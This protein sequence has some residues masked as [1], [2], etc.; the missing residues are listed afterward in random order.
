[1]KSVFIPQSRDIKFNGVKRV[2]IVARLHTNALCVQIK[3]ELVRHVKR[4]CCRDRS[5]IC[6]P[7]R[8]A[9][10]LDITVQCVEEPYCIPRRKS[11]LQ[12]KIKVPTGTY[13]PARSR[14]GLFVGGTAFSCVHRRR[15]LHAN[16]FMLARGV[17]GVNSCRF[18][19]LFLKVN[20]TQ[21]SHTPLGFTRPTAR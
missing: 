9:N 11:D 10:K 19:G 3:K 12:M 20:Q 6:S 17:G 2:F 16:V 13:S 15:S 5:Y 1:M 4:F 7:N 14:K 8:S 21:P 18:T